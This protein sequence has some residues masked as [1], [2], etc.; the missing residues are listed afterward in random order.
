M[1]MLLLEQKTKRGYDEDTEGPLSRTHFD[2]GKGN[3][4]D[5][6]AEVRVEAHQ[7]I[8]RSNAEKKSKGIG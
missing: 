3:L 6:T 4:T 8:S 1:R 7:N 2:R 5:L